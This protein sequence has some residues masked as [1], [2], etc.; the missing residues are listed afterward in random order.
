MVTCYERRLWE[1]VKIRIFDF[2][3]YFEVHHRISS[4]V[5]TAFCSV[6]IYFFWVKF[7]IL[8]RGNNRLCCEK[9][10]V[11]VRTKLM[12]LSAERFWPIQSLWTNKA[13]VFLVCTRLGMIYLTCLTFRLFYDSSSASF[14]RI[15]YAVINDNYRIG[16]A[17]LEQRAF[18]K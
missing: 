9:Q 11:L 14:V 6:I 8:I 4:T 2:N 16:S 15:L 5:S 10:L 13:N 17:I 3:C 12:K 7:M 1:L 18:W